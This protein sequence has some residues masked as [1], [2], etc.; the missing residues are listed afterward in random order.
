MNMLPGRISDGAFWLEDQR[1]G[2]AGG[3]PAGPC[4]LGFRPEWAT[5]EP[6]DLVADADSVAGGV[7]D[8]V[9]VTVT[10]SRALGVEHH[11]PVGIVTAELNGRT[12]HTRQPVDL[13]RGKT[14]R[15]KLQPERLLAFRE[16]WRL[17][18]AAAGIGDG[19]P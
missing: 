7:A 16:G 12:L 6:L 8:G 5:V 17:K 19:L 2:S 1:V 14:A 13:A 9:A 4:T 15:L 11:R 10:G 3:L 18:G